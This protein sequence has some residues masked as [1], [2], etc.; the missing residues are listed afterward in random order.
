MPKGLSQQQRRILAQLAVAKRPL[1]SDELLDLLSGS[2]LRSRTVTR[3]VDHSAHSAI[4]DSSASSAH[5]RRTVDTRSCSPAPST[6]HRG[7]C[8]VPTFKEPAE[9]RRTHE[10]RHDGARARVGVRGQSV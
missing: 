10:Q 2:S 6:A 4:T 7:S 9:T 5:R 8:A 3:Y 1:A